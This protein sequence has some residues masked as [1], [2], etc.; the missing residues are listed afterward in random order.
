MHCRLAT[1]WSIFSLKYL[2]YIPHMSF[3]LWVQTL[4]HV[5]RRGCC[6]RVIDEQSQ[7]LC[8]CSHTNQ[9]PKVHVVNHCYYRRLYIYCGTI[10]QDIAP[11][12]ITSKVKLQSDFNKHPY[13]VL[14]ASYVCLSWV[15]WRN[16]TARY[17]ECTALTE[18]TKNGHMNV[19]ATELRPVDV[20]AQHFN[21]L[22]H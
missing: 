18:A 2:Q 12:T 9:C 13:R 4:D 21:K 16:V 5:F 7:R 17:R 19:D 1:I 22:H 14:T 15:L 8:L 6:D 11:G 10:W 20:D 3:V